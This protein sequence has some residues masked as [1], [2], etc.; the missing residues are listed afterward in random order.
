MGKIQA[1]SI[2]RL[3]PLIGDLG[4]FLWAFTLKMVCLAWVM[5]IESKNKN[6]QTI[7]TK[8]QSET[9]STTDA[10]LVTAFPDPVHVA[11]NDR[12]SF[13]NWYRLV[14]GYRVNLVL[15]RTARTDPILKEIL[16][17]PFIPSYMPK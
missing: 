3:V 17:A 11:K 12:A 6:S 1:K 13:P 7:L 15:L 14:D 2:F 8:R 10:D 4:R 5:D 16:L 9:E